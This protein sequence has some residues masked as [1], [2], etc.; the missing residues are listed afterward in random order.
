MIRLVIVDDDH[1]LLARMRE[2]FMT[3]ADLRLVGVHN[4]A[5]GAMKDTDWT[6]VDVLVTDLDMPQTSGI[7]LIAA[8]TQLNTSLVA[9]A[10]TVHERRESLYAALRAGASGYV[11]KETDAHELC[12]AVRACARGES[13]ISPPVARHLIREFKQVP[14]ASSADSLSAR[15]TE[16][17]QALADGF[18]YKEVAARFQ[19]SIHTVHNHVKNIHG[20]LHAASR[21]EAIRTARLHGY[22][23]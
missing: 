13:P 18:L 23:R 2:A 9:L 14:D 4:S 1:Q 11:L 15:E 21:Q 7:A 10:Y 20:K 6:Q 22:L 16:I 19:L 5:Y 3:Q 17:L 12:D 8:A